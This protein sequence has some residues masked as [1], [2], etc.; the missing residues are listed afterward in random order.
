MFYLYLNGD[1]S[2]IGNGLSFLNGKK[3]NKSDVKIC[4]INL[5]QKKNYFIL[6]CY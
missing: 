6:H 3:E 2:G 1:G 4:M 5:K